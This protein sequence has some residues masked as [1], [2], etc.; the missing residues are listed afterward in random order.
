MVGNYT[1]KLLVRIKERVELLVDVQGLCLSPLH[2][3]IAVGT[4]IQWVGKDDATRQREEFLKAENEKFQ[5][6][7]DSF[8]DDLVNSTDDAWTLCGFVNGARR[9]R[10]TNT[11]PPLPVFNYLSNVYISFV[12]TLA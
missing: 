6:A 2:L 10:A 1:K 8:M 7:G 3:L 5:E 12:V 4:V 11:G 9:V